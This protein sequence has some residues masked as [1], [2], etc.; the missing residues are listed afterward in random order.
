MGTRAYHIVSVL[1]E[2]L[3]SLGDWKDRHLWP[4]V[5][6]GL[7]IALGDGW[8]RC[9][10]A[11][12]LPT[13]VPSFPLAGKREY[14]LLHILALGHKALGWGFGMGDVLRVG[15]HALQAKSYNLRMFDMLV[16]LLMALSTFGKGGS[17]WGCPGDF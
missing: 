6:L 10:T 17:S 14:G 12:V 16:S 1:S 9:L 13:S 2:A 5:L 11:H 7:G 4:F 3:I 15:H 8:V